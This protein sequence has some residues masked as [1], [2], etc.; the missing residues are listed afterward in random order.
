M[1]SKYVSFYLYRPS[2]TWDNYRT[3][4]AIIISKPISTVSQKF[5][6]HFLNL[7]SVEFHVLTM[8]LKTTLYAIPIDS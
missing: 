5:P 2:A 1:Q 6:E 7:Y 4:I 3:K 8:K